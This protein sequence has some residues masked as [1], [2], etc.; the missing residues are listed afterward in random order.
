MKPSYWH[1]QTPATP[2]FPDIQWS[3]PQQRALA[4]KLVLIGGNKLGFA[5]VASAYEA[6]L[7]AGIGECRAVLP[8]ALKKSLDAQFD[9]VFLPTNPSGGFSKGAA[10]D[11]QAYAAWGDGLLLIGDAGRNAETAMLYEQLLGSDRPLVLTRDALDMVRGQAATWL[12]NPQICAVATF[13]QLQKLFQEVHYP[14][15]LL[16][17]MQLAQL[18]DTLHKFTISYPAKIITLHQGQLIVA[19][20]G[21]VSTTP[22]EDNLM[23]WRG[24]MATRA[25]VYWLQHPKKPFEA[26]TTAIIAK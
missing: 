11:L 10:R 15:M 18:V 13:A 17:R 1:T 24:I 2:L 25:S 3:K 21:E 12:E 22:C 9:G 4:G 6:A 14:K 8:D 20:D 26:L 23:I 5:A 19:S 7:A 16:F